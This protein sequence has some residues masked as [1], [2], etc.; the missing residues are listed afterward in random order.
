[1]E[2]RTLLKQ[3]ITKVTKILFFFFRKGKDIPERTRLKGV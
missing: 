1:M 2:G 3:D